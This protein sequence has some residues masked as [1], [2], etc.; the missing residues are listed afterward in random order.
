MRVFK[1]FIIVF[2]LGIFNINYVYSL[3]NPFVETNSMEEAFDYS[4]FTFNIPY[5]FDDS[6]DVIYRV[7]PNELLEI[8]FNNGDCDISFR[9][10]PSDKYVD[11]SGD[12]NIYNSNYNIYLNNTKILLRGNHDLISS[13]TWFKDNY[14]YAISI[15]LCGMGI[16]DKYLLD[17]I[18]KIF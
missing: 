3:H 10:M 12:Y 5:I 13:A 2:V 16:G 11:I 14:S 6:Y 17:I 18:P 1:V 7:I 4:G 9:K 15:D 8:R